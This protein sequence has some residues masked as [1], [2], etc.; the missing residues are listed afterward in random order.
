VAQGDLLQ[1]QPAEK[2]DRIALEIPA[3]F[4]A[5]V[6]REPAPAV[7]LVALD[8]CQRVVHESLPGLWLVGALIDRRRPSRTQ[9]SRLIERAGRLPPLFALHPVAEHV[10]VAALEDARR[11][12]PF[13]LRGHVVTRSF[14]R[15]IQSLRRVSGGCARQWA[16]G[17]HHSPSPDFGRA[18][19]AEVSAE[20][21]RGVQSRIGPS[22]PAEGGPAGATLTGSAPGATSV[23]RRTTPRCLPRRYA[24]C[25][26]GCP[27][28][29][30]PRVL[31]AG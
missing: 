16:S 26:S 27:P 20:Q 24:R 3:V 7:A 17:L 14:C 15:R 21:R 5:R 25:S 2:G 1:P 23:V 18:F 10:P 12:G 28:T 6:L 9:P 4:G 29:S 11:L 13:A 30:S 19:L 8:P 22:G 31:G